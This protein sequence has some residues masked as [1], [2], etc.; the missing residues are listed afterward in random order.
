MILTRK[1]PKNVSTFHLK[2]AINTS[3]INVWRNKN[4]DSETLNA[5]VESHNIDNFKKLE[6]GYNIEPSL[7]SMT[8][9]HN[10]HA[11]IIALNATNA[12]DLCFL[13]S[14]YFQIPSFCEYLYANGANISSRNPDDCS[15]LDIAILADHAEIASFLFSKGIEIDEKAFYYAVSSNSTVM[16]ELLVS[17][18]ADVNFR[19]NN[20]GF[21]M[22]H[23]ACLNCNIKVVEILISHGINI[24]DNEDVRG[25]TPLVIAS[26]MHYKEIA[27][28]LLS[29]G[30]STNIQDKNGKM[31]IH[32][33]IVPDCQGFTEFITNKIEY[34]N[35]HSRYQ[36]SLPIVENFSDM[37]VLL[38]SNGADVNAKK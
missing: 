33:A 21:S 36:P 8:F 14:P 6:F 18:G 2:G 11:Y 32:H 20:T 12:V 17:H 3:L 27:E 23:I 24:N 26:M 35:F 37:I 7:R 22:L 30:A 13:Y 34:L 1:S 9:Y 28:F 10:L 38:L 25:F 16:V 29:H 19:E 31:A 5:I 4:P 15:T